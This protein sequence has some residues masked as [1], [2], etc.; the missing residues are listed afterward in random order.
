MKSYFIDCS[1]IRRRGWREKRVM[2]GVRSDAA[3]MTAGGSRL[4]QVSCSSLFLVEPGVA[5]IKTPNETALKANER[6]NKEGICQ[7]IFV[8][9]FISPLETEVGR[10]ERRRLS[11]P[12]Y[13]S[14]LWRY[15]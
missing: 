8:E 7:R 3:V 12:G 2:S 13:T 15:N 14:G 6:K 1:H 9:H 5:E 11:S 10:D 4:L